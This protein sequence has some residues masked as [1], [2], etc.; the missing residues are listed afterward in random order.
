M[1]GAQIELDRSNITGVEVQLDNAE[2]KLL[3]ITYYLLN[4]TSDR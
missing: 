2:N 3:K 4:V 1:Q